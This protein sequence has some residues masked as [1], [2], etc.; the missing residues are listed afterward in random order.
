V[1]SNPYI[2]AT[3]ALLSTLGHYQVRMYKRKPLLASKRKRLLVGLKEVNKRLDRMERQTH[4]WSTVRPLLAVLVARNIECAQ[5]GVSHR[6]VADIV[7]KCQHL[8]IPVLFPLTRRQAGKALMSVT[9]RHS[10]VSA[11]GILS[12]DGAKEAFEQAIHLATQAETVFAQQFA[13]GTVA[14]EV[15]LVSPLVLACE[16]G[17]SM[18]VK[19]TCLQAGHPLDG[20]DPKT[21]S[22]ALHM[23]AMQDDVVTCQWLYAQSHNVMNVRNFAG[24]TAY[25]TACRI[26]SKQ[27]VQWMRTLE[28]SFHSIPSWSGVTAVSLFSNAP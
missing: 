19:E 23:A 1:T 16:Y 17:Y 26:H 11:C 2:S 13:Y 28:G 14:S 9:K 18:V 8:Q 22:T 25:F 7:R 27:V 3:T 24:E 6:L 15:W 4:S 20:V 5:D 12:F 10:S 21:G